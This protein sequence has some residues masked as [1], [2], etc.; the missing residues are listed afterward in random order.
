MARVRVIQ[1]AVNAG[2]WSPLLEG[3]SDLAK[4]HSSA[5]KI[6]NL[7]CAKFGGVSR[8]PGTHFVAEVKTSAKRTRLI[9]F[10][11][12]TVQ[13][14]VIEVGHQYVRF[15]RNNG[16]VENPPA[17]AIE[18][19]TPYLEA[20]IFDIHFTQ[21]ADTM[22]LAHS[23]HA[24]MKLTR[25]SDI[26]W[27]LTA[28]DFQD[29]PYLPEKTDLTITPSA[30]T[31]VGITLTASA[32][33]FLAGHVGSI[34][35][36]KHGVVWG[37][38]KITA[39]TST[40]VVTATVVKNFGANTAS[41]AYREGAWST[42]RGF[43]GSVTL[44]QQRSW[45]ACTA[46]NPD[47][48]W[49]SQTSEYENM[50]PGTALDDESI[51]FTLSSNKVNA[52]RW[53]APSRALLSGTTG[54]EWNISGGDPTIPIT[55]ANP[56]ARA[57]TTHGSNTVSPIQV[58]NATLFLQ[59]AGNRLREYTYD[60]PTDS[61]SAPDMTLLCEHVTKGGIVQ[62]DY[63]QER[64]SVIWMVRAD[65]TLVG[66]TY[67]RQQ[68]VVAAHRHIT[69][70]IGDL[71]DGNFESVAV[72]PHPTVDE[73]ETWVIV[74]RR[75]LS[76][77]T[78]I[79]SWT[80]NPLILHKTVVVF[81]CPGHGFIAGESIVISGV[82]VAAFNGTHLVDDPIIDANTFSITILV[83]LSSPNSGTGGFAVASAGAT[84]KRYVEYLDTQGG[85]YGNLQ[86]DAA[87]TYTGA[88][89]ATLTG[90]SHLEGQ[91]VDILAMGSVYPQ[92]A[93]IAG[94]VTG[95]NPKVTQAEVGLHFN[96]TLLTMRPEA[97]GDA[98]TAQGARKRFNEVICR[99][100][101][102]IGVTINGDR[103]EFRTSADPMDAS[104]PLFSGD[105]KVTNLGFDTDGRIEIKQTSPLPF[106]LLTLIGTLFVGE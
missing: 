47:T 16:R 65:G 18:V 67:E 58:H 11:F 10:V 94:Q 74:K 91:T 13:A 31:G 64:D 54:Q 33:V 30:V 19:A 3:R 42:V 49:G 52:I 32:P 92:Q 2:E 9:P 66:I 61:Y 41:V 60:F 43:P 88:A 104:V 34:W 27:T 69:G 76:A 68:D 39:F 78:A 45:W 7:I 44:F 6:E 73:D 82:S 37:Y 40:T 51:T 59:R 26:A 17:T 90:L 80:R 48:I 85:F 50:D 24:P 14:Y 100:N 62:M 97:G 4:Y 63:Q 53:I 106:T 25:T 95:L 29:G 102:T 46:N 22:Y 96:S 15:Y 77:P 38:A 99:L 89:T 28:I 98:G 93:V 23:L 20:E 103:M 87:L 70:S 55:P 101:S 35:R 72:I 83:Y 105:K 79:T 36:L 57:E 86:T 12:S 81:T 56:N 1:N 84:Y 8:R 71:S 21:S 75:F 5:K